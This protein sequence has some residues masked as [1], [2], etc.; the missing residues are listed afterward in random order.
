MSALT[1]LL[2]TG[3]R[4]L[5]PAM[6]QPNPLQNLLLSAPD[7]PPV[8]SACQLQS[9][10]VLA[11]VSVEMDILDM[12]SAL[13]SLEALSLAG[14][15]MHGYDEYLIEESESPLFFEDLEGLSALR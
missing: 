11:L 13:T 1:K 8:Q 5:T 2:A 14:Y 9:L 6:R 7:G 3:R 10:K 12:L 15:L 4:L